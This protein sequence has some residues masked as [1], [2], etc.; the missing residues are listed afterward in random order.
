MGIDPSTHQPLLLAASNNNSSKINSN[1]QIKTSSP[2]PSPSSSSSSYTTATANDHHDTIVTA[3]GV[4]DSVI[5]IM[6]GAPN[7]HL[8]GSS[9]GGLGA[10][11]PISMRYTNMKHH[12][13]HQNL[14]ENQAMAMKDGINPC[15]STVINPQP[16]S[17]ITAREEKH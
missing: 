1:H 15:E 8:I 10:P 5:N 16:S 2:S 3:G 4:K 6:Q 14:Q 11:I 13:S 12:E 7:S 17:L 9:Y